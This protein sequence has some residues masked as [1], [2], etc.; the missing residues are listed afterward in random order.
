VKDGA[1]FQTRIKLGDSVPIQ[2]IPLKA[3]GARPPGMKDVKLGPDDTSVKPPRKSF[4]QE[5][6]RVTNIHHRSCVS[7]TS[8]LT[9][10]VSASPFSTVV[11]RGYHGGVYVP[12]KCG[13]AA[14]EDCRWWGTGCWGSCACCKIDC[15]GLM[16][17]MPPLAFLHQEHDSDQAIFIIFALVNRIATKLRV[18]TLDSQ[19]PVRTAYGSNQ[20]TENDA[21][22][23]GFHACFGEQIACKRHIFYAGICI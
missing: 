1:V 12:R 23:N 3:V 11:Y 10:C 17:A 19:P 14:G 6:V 18:E 9:H 8:A 15:A 7:L 2:W 13:G 5:Y 4:L 21:L 20:K 16:V 22:R